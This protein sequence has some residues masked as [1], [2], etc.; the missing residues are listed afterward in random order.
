ML[1][2]NL[3]LVPES[4]RGRGG[5]P[6]HPSWPE[7]L[8]SRRNL[9]G[10]ANL[11]GWWKRKKTA[12][13]STVSEVVTCTHLHCYLPHQC[14]VL[15]GNSCLVGAL[16]WI[17]LSILNDKSVSSCPSRL[18]QSPASKDTPSMSS[19]RSSI[20]RMS[21]RSAAKKK[22]D[23]SKSTGRHDGRR[24]SNL[25]CCLRS[26]G[27]CTDLQPTKHSLN[28]WSQMGFLWEY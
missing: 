16:S 22:R 4:H 20:F 21:T 9:L 2:F 5:R 1:V 14:S 28:G 17:F 10:M 7:L 23:V 3:S 24:K 18:T 15:L 12:E 11:E 6:E 13:Q 19:D 27:T 8:S 26:R 25:D